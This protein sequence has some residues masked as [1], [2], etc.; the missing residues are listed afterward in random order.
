M[1]ALEGVHLSGSP[2]DD[3]EVAAQH[4]QL[5][6]CASCDPDP[7]LAGQEGL[8]LLLQVDVLLDQDLQEVA[9]QQEGEGRVEA[10]VDPEVVDYLG[11]LL[12]V[13]AAIYYSPIQI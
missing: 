7:E 8:Q 2:A 1:A 3:R 13:H 12:V 9:V 5:G 6:Q 10:V 11:D 4:L